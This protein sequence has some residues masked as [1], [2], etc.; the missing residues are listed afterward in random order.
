[1]VYHVRPD[2]EAAQLDD[3]AAIA[4]NIGGL[5]SYIPSDKHLNWKEIRRDGRVWCIEIKVKKGKKETG[6]T[7]ELFDKTVDARNKVN[8]YVRQDKISPAARDVTIDWTALKVDYTEGAEEMH[9]PFTEIENVALRTLLL[10]TAKDMSDYSTTDPNVASNRPM[11]RSNP[12]EINDKAWYNASRISVEDYVGTAHEDLDKFLR[13]H[14][15]PD[16]AKTALAKIKAAADFIQVFRENLESEVKARE[17]KLADPDLA[18]D[19]RATR[20]RLNRQIQQLKALIAKLDAR[21]LDTMAIFRSVPY[22]NDSLYDFDNPAEMLTRSKLSQQEMQDHL[23]ATLDLPHDAAYPIAY[24]QDKGNLLI[25]DRWQ[26]EA[27][28]DDRG[29]EKKGP[30]M[31]EFVV[32]N[33]LNLNKRPLILIDNPKFYETFI[34]DAMSSLALPNDGDLKAI[35]TEALEKTRDTVYTNYNGG[36]SD[37]YG[38]SYP[39]HINKIQGNTDFQSQIPILFP[40]NRPIHEIRADRDA[41]AMM[42]QQL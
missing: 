20:A 26:Y 6:I 8:E 5:P 35:V 7:Q 29:G 31:E 18:I 19:D 16:L 28:V 34:Q 14:K 21:A 1:M 38:K 17:K 33:I 32:Y 37:L 39:G 3:L 12:L 22:A 24:S 30:S 4:E 23:F 41:R 9:L 11:N 15:L 36:D 10:D 2:A 40:R 27:W 42:R 13:H 25:H